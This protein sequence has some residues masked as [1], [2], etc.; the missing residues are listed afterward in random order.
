MVIICITCFNDQCFVFKGL[1]RFSVL[2]AIISLNSNQMM[3][4]MVKYN[5]LFEVRTELLN[6]YTNFE[7]RLQKAKPNTENVR[8]LNL[9]AVKL[10]IFQV[11]KLP[12]IRRLS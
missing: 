5:A 2:S 10:M 9:A 4:V 11:T 6:I 3:F 7:F 12:L 1:V 8:C